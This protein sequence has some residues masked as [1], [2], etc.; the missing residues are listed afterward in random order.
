MAFPNHVWKQWIPRFSCLNSSSNKPEN[1]LTWK[2]FLIIIFTLTSGFSLSQ[3][4]VWSCIWLRRVCKSKC[5][6]YVHVYYDCTWVSSNL[7]SLKSAFVASPWFLYILVSNVLWLSD[8]GRGRDKLHCVIEVLVYT[9]GII[10]PWYFERQTEESCFV[11]F[12]VNC[13][14]MSLAGV[15]F[16]VCACTCTHTTYHFTFNLCL[17]TYR[18]ARLTGIVASFTLT[19]L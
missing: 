7:C 19:L 12:L 6:I 13:L 3:R 18:T 5:P 4:M 15:I 10:S 11:S 14:V 1:L 8:T 16:F 17:C 2:G 9:S